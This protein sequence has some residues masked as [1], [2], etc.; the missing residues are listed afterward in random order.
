MLKAL[1][2][3]EFLVVNIFRIARNPF[4]MILSAPSLLDFSYGADPR[5]LLIYV[6]CEEIPATTA[7]NN[8]IYLVSLISSMN[9]EEE[10]MKERWEANSFDVALHFIPKE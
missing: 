6:H 8:V 1:T 9:K 5:S 7:S 4:D 10:G 3:F 2:V